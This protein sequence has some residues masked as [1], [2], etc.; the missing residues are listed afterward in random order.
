MVGWIRLE[1]KAPF[2]PRPV[3]ECPAGLPLLAMDVPADPSP[4]RLDRAVR[5]LRRRGVRRCLAPAGFD[6]W[7]RLIGAGISQVD[8]LPLCLA[9]GAELAL[10]RVSTLSP[11]F[12]RVALRGEQ[13]DRAARRLADALCPRVGALLLDFDRGEEELGERLRSRYGAA[14]LHL[15]KGECP[16]VSVELSPR[17]P[18]GEFTLRLWGE[19]DLGG[20]DLICPAAVPDGIEPLRFL[21]LLWETGR[22][23]AEEIRPVFALDRT[24]E[25]NI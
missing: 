9:K 25:N 4:K 11:R 23:P 2:R 24:G 7:D 18:L 20:L 13:A 21:T 15:G 1:E 22:V 10:F 19:P 16:Q 12:R 3:V 6:G 14:P 5:A 8:P 17:P